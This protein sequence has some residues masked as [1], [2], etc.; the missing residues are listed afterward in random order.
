[1]KIE[2]I[3]TIFGLV[4]AILDALKNFLTASKKSSSDGSKGHEENS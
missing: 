3:L 1:M 2:K 4:S